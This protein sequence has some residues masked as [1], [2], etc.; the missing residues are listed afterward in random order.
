MF[1][2]NILLL[3]SAV[4]WRYRSFEQFP[5]NRFFGISAKGLIFIAAWIETEVMKWWED[6]VQNSSF[7]V[8]PIPYPTDT[9]YLLTILCILQ[10][11]T[12]VTVCVGHLQVIILFGTCAG[13][14]II[15]L[16]V[17]FVLCEGL[18]FIPFPMIFY[19]YNCLY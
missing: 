2:R 10:F 16:N 8:Y 9:G 19:T 7:G 12:C 14:E 6:S 13:T 1:Q 4:A 18:R 5:P 17:Y 11:L 3:S 15:I